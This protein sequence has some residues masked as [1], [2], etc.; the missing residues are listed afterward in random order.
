MCFL[1]E[2][3]KAAIIPDTPR[4]VKAQDW[5]QCQRQLLFQAAQKSGP[6]LIKHCPGGMFGGFFATNIGHFRPLGIEGWR[7]AF[8]FVAAVSLVVC[9]MVLRYAADPRRKVGSLAR[10]A[11]SQQTLSPEP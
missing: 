11:H 10:T 7:F 1:D 6:S 4:L 2:Q 9:V 8:H 5:H 3:L